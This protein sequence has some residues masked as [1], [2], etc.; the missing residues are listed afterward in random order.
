METKE[1][2][3]PEL[4]IERRQAV[5]PWWVWLVGALILAL[6]IWAI[7]AAT[8]TDRRTAAVP[9]QE[10]V[11]GTQEELLPVIVIVTN[12]AAYFNK[13]VSG[14]ATVGEVVSDRGF[15]LRQDDRR[16][17][18]V[19]DEP[20]P[21][22]KDLNEGQRVRVSGIIYDSQR[23]GAAPGTSESRSRRASDH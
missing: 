10:R 15:W 1:E 12:P 9:P 19:I 5:I 21:E 17:F 8:T 22:T 23:M 20:R 3:M 11:A 7:V 14:T 6:L 4:H 13:T 2:D 18:A 16:I